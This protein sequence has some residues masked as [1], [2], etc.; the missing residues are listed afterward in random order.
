MTPSRGLRVKREGLRFDIDLAKARIPGGWSRVYDLR[1]LQKFEEALSP[2]NIK[3]N[4]TR[5]IFE[6]DYHLRSFLH[7]E[8]ASYYG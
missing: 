1:H 6:F 4:D 8:D 2:R 7:R 5:S 3:D